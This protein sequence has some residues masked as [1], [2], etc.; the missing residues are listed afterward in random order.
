MKE[1]S[2]AM[3]A[4]NKAL[5]LDKDNK[6]RKIQEFLGNME[7]FNRQV[8]MSCSLCFENFTV[9]SQKL[10][11]GST[12]GHAEMLCQLNNTFLWPW[13]SKK[14]SHGWSWSPGGYKLTLHIAV[15]YSHAF[16]QFSI[17]ISFTT[18]VC[19]FVTFQEILSDPAM[20][21][22]LEQMTENPG[23]IQEWVFLKPP[24]NLLR[25]RNLA[26]LLIAIS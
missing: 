16:N 12:R 20:R 14:K 1:F 18:L 9:F 10:N 3:D 2:K 11:L 23:A 25:T 7:V 15:Q 21:L 22:I 6:V 13:G 19:L 26:A 8:V 4:Y 24:I 5:E 17:C